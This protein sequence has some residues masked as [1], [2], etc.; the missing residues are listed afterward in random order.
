MNASY[1]FHF[2]LKWAFGVECS[3]IDMYAGKEVPSVGFV[4]FVLVFTRDATVFVGVSLFIPEISK[5]AFKK[6]IGS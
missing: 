3:T 4:C 1:I 2:L 6:L 5:R